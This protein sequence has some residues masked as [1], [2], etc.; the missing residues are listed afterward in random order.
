MEK[1]IINQEDETITSAQ[2]IS[3]EIFPCYL[4]G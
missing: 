4:T 3:S 1:G 2:I